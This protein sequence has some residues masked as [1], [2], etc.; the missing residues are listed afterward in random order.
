MKPYSRSF[1]SISIFLFLITAYNFSLFAQKKSTD[2][3][4]LPDVLIVKLK[5]ANSAYFSDA[6]SLEGFNILIT[7]IKAEKIIRLFPNSTP[8]S[9][10]GHVDLTRIYSIT[11]SNIEKSALP[12]FAKQLKSYGAFEYVELHYIDQQHAA[13]FVPNEPAA[14]INDYQRYLSRMQAYEAWAIEKGNPNVV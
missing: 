4:Y 13:V 8:P 10:K 9:Q 7:P 12:D 14:A 5:P 6:L 3:D 1:V 2:S 11:F